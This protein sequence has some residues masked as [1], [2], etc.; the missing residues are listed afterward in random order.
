MKHHFVFY[1]PISC[2]PLS[3]DNGAAFA[4]S[5]VILA[6]RR[7]PVLVIRKLPFTMCK[8]FAPKL[9]SVVRVQASPLIICQCPLAGQE[10]ES[11]GGSP[12]E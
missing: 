11:A 3:I 2:P 1:V 4:F 8:V 10:Q 7:T 12:L 6:N 9:H 5:I